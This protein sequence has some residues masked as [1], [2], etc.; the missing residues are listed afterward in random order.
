MSTTVISSEIVPQYLDELRSLFVAEWESVD[1]FG[2][3]AYGR[4]PPPPLLAL[5][6]GILVGG[7]SFTWFRSEGDSEI[8][9]W[10]NAVLVKPQ[11]RGRGIATSLISEAAQIA[12]NTDEKELYV[13][14]EI[15]DLYTKL[16]WQK[17]RC[18]GP[19]NI[20]KR[21]LFKGGP[22]HP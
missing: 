16:N 5:E 11:F 14:T 22:K 15:P 3:K 18:H 9:L 4:N 2:G 17:V 6:S 20:L 21:A 8:K 13:Y 10:I 12:S 19:N 1:S 7:L